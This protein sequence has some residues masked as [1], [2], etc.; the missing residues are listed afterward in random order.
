MPNL[1]FFFFYYRCQESVC[2]Y[3]FCNS[4]KASCKFTFPFLDWGGVERKG[5]FFFFLFA[6]ILFM[7][8]LWTQGN[9]AE[10]T[11]NITLSYKPGF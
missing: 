4:H 5:D 8:L 2:T 3:I 11:S 10:Q 9:A 6:Y 7:D 1:P